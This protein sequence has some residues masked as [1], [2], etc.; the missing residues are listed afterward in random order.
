MGEGDAGDLGALSAAGDADANPNMA[1]PSSR[2]R[3]AGQGRAATHAIG[4][5]SARCDAIGRLVA[6]RVFY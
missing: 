2:P 5:K 6:G 1:V 4:W 3:A